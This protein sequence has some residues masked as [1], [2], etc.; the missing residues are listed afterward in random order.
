M[1]SGA[2]VATRKSPRLHAPD[3]VEIQA[4]TAQARA[5]A[6]EKRQVKALLAKAEA[7]TVAAMA[8]LRA[9]QAECRVRRAAAGGG[10]GGAKRWG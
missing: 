1:N 5:A 3:A 8:M 10:G 4:T 2:A 9:S 6:D 7:A